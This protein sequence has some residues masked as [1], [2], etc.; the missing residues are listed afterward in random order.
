MFVVRRK[1]TYTCI[2]QST[3]STY[4]WFYTVPV[5]YLYWSSFEKSLKYHSYSQLWNPPPK[6]KIKLIFLK[7][8]FFS[9]FIY[10]YMYIKDGITRSNCRNLSTNVFSYTGQFLQC[11]PNIWQTPTGQDESLFTF[12]IWSQTPCTSSYLEDYAS[13]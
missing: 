10:L 2:S 13:E 4:M 9:W 1:C 7:T 5:L 6:K 8:C 12:P 11:L 3:H